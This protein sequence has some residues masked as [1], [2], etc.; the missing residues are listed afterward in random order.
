MLEAIDHVILPVR[1][2][3]A[4]AEPFERL[5]LRLTPKAGHQGAG[6]S[7]RVFFVGGEKSQFYVELLTVD[8]EAAARRAGNREDI[9]EA[10]QSDAGLARVMFRSDDV[11]GDAARLQAHGGGP[12]Y[13]AKREDGT[14]I[15]NVTRLPAET[16]FGA[17]A[18]QYVVAPNEQYEARKGRGLFESDFPLKR[19]DHLAAIAPDIDGTTDFWTE[20]L[21]VPVFGEVTTPAMVI[22]QMK[23]GDAILEL[24]GPSGPESP[25]AARPAGL[26]SM[27]AFEV[28]DLDTLVATARERGFTVTDPSTG[29]LPG[30]RTATIPGDQLSGMSMQLLEYT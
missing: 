2:L 10:L 4:A 5:G 21:G 30:T 3:D 13:D 14:K 11:R 19:L 26:V 15:C 22:R 28:E 12:L 24:L 17:G 23:L 9:I 1:S 20:V 6:T 7:N 18:I 29:V 27:C 8:D 16:G 25:V